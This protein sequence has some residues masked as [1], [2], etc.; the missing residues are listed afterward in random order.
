MTSGEEI[1]PFLI[2]SLNPVI[3]KPQ[4]HIGIVKARD[5]IPMQIDRVKFDMCNRVPYRDAPLRAS[6]GGGRVLRAGV[7]L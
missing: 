6:G 4:R 7:A 5:Q 3:I 1:E 2:R